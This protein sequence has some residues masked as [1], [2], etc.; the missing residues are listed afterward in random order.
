MPI[1]KFPEEWLCTAMKELGGSGTVL[2]IAKKIWELYSFEIIASGEKMLYSWQY[3]F[4][5]TA[6]NMRK[7]GKLGDIKKG[8]WCLLSND[9]ETSS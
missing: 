3:D 7:K 9:N 5:W 8:L 2:D 6:T 4:R 1:D